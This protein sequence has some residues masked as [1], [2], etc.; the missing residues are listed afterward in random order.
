VQLELAG[1]TTEIDKFLI[2]RMMDPVLHLV[3]N[4]VSH[5]IETPDARVARGKRPEGTI[6]LGASTAGESV[7]I[8]VTDDGEGIDL[9]AVLARARA[10]GMNV[11]DGP[12]DERALL[13]IICAS[14]FST[15]DEAD[16]GSGRGVGMAVVRRTVQELGGTLGV[17]TAEGR[18]TTF[19]IAL[20]LTLAITDAIIAQVG[21]HTFA[22][23]QSSVRE[24]IEVEAAAVYPLEH[25]EL[26]TH[27][28]TSL[29]IVRLANL[30]GITVDRRPRLHA[31]VAGAGLAA[32]GLL[33]DRIIGQREIVVKTVTDPL[34]RVRGVSGATELGDGRLVLILDLAALIPSKQG[35]PSTLH[36][37]SA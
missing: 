35:A 2:E 12:F 15:R 6:R 16:R 33:V 13:D 14:G 7:V 11:P 23:P 9:H 28:G 4:A 1:Q 36:G 8:E 37:L 25:N 18:G 26:M 31:I 32:V 34:I 22:I 3:R 27:R 5:A 24:V 21:D 17:R 29:P 20:P 10:R 19:T 30:F